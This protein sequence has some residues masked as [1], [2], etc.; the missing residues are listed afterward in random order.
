MKQV[1]TDFINPH[2]VARKV[3]EGSLDATLVVLFRPPE[4]VAVSCHRHS[5]LKVL[6]ELEG[7]EPS[8]PNAHNVVSEQCV[9]YTTARDKSSL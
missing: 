6:V 3:S 1:V 2:N 7:I 8:S 4:M 9:P 5:I